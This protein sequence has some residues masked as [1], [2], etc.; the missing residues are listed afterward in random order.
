[1][2]EAVTAAHLSK[3]EAVKVVHDGSDGANI[4]ENMLYFLESG[5]VKI[6]YRERL[7]MKSTKE[8]KCS[9]SS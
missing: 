5:E 1:M 8:L 6:I 3:L 4:K 2:D 7:L 9:L